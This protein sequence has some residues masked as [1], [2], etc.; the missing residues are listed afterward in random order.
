MIAWTRPGG[1]GRDQL[2]CDPAEEAH[3]VESL[4]R[5]DAA[6]SSAAMVGGAD[7]HPA[8]ADVQAPSLWYEGVLDRA[9]TP[10]DLQLAVLFGVETHLISGADHVA[11]F[12]QSGDVLRVVRPFLDK[13]RL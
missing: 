11:V 2:Q 4:A 3:H 12:R 8:V 13:H 5:N 1:W 6:A 7:R 9:F 10:E